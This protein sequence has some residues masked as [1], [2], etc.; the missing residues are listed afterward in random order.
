MSAY[1]YIN[2]MERNDVALYI[3]FVDIIY[4]RLLDKIIGLVQYIAAICRERPYNK[5]PSIFHTQHNVD[6]TC[7]PHDYKY[8]FNLLAIFWSQYAFKSQISK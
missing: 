4:K 8:L 6:L 5:S 7:I 2:I 3:N 1:M